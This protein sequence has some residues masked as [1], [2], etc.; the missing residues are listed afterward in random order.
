MFRSQKLLLTIFIFILLFSI[1]FSQVRDPRTLKFQPIMFEPPSPT[2]F[3]LDDGMVVYFLEDH[4]LPVITMQALVKTGRIYEPEDKVG[5][6]WIT[7]EVMRNGGTSSLTAEEVNE[8]LDYTA[9]TVESEIGLEQGK[10]T[11]DCLSKYLDQAL[12]IYSEILKNPRFDGEKVNLEKEKAKEEIR[13][14]ND[15]PDDIASREFSKLLY[16]GHPYGWMPTFQTIDNITKEDL[17]FFHRRFFHPNNVILAVSGD[18]TPEQLKDKLTKFFGDWEK[19]DLVLP[20]IS[21]VELSF[22]EKINYIFKDINQTNIW[23]GHLGYKQDNPDRFAI[24]VMNF[25]LGGGGFTSRLTSQIRVE[26]GLAY[27]VYSYFNKRKDLGGFFA[28]CQTKGE[29]TFEAL[30]LMREVIKKLQETGAT[31][32]ELKLAKDYILNSEVF[33][34]STP[35]KIVN[36]QAQSEFDGFPSDQMKKDIEEIKKV[37]LSDIQRVAKEYLHPDKMIILLVGNKDL[38]ERPLS[39]LGETKEIKLEEFK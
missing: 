23:I 4:E 26:Q 17:V 24:Y 6:A 25:I 38:F 39:E 36:Q 14:Q 12:K 20:S 19:K 5:L 10:V 31:E 34:Y 16:P 27:D 18:I 32:Q 1:S 22:K 3:T 37:S 35:E 8:A 15:R 21:Q 28:V 9:A 33:R 13:R 29:T 11:L 2:R 30:S 7:G